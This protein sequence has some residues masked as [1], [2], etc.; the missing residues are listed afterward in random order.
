MS[1]V[2]AKVLGLAV[3]LKELQDLNFPVRPWLFH[4][5]RHSF[6]PRAL[7]RIPVLLLLVLV[8][9]LL[10]LLVVFIPSSY[11]ETS[12]L[13]HPPLSFCLLASPPSSSP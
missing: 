5:R 10:L 6:D 8:H 1:E 11:F 7:W 3:P 2:G 12:T 9:S 4:E 13:L